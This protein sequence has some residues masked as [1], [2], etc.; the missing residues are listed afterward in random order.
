MARFPAFWPGRRP[1]GTPASPILETLPTFGK[2]IET[3]S[4]RWKWKTI[5]MSLS[6]HTYQHGH[7]WSSCHDSIWFNLIDCISKNTKALT[8]FLHSLSLINWNLFICTSDRDKVPRMHKQ[9]L[10]SCSV[11]TMEHR[12]LPKHPGHLPKSIKKT[13]HLLTTVHVIVYQ[14]P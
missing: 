2:L 9:A 7:D 8:C 3:E 6:S 4:E 14:S 1:A 12:T 11:R 5:S 10:T 13:N